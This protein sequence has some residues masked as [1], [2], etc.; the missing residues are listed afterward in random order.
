MS[1]VPVDAGQLDH[2]LASQVPFGRSR[3]LGFCGAALFG[4]ATRL[5]TP[6]LASAAHGNVPSPCFGFATCHCC[7]G[8][9]CCES[10][11]YW[12]SSHHHG[13]PTGGQCWNSCNYDAQGCC[14]SYRCCD[15]HSSGGLCLCRS[16]RGKICPA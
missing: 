15:W 9:S 4:V 6:K 11:C 14:Y 10:G 3:F 1:V 12:H 13:C 2:R 5:V 16:Y 7:S 8:T